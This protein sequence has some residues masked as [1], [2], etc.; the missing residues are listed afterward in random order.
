MDELKSCRTVLSYTLKF[1]LDDTLPEI[2]LFT[3]FSDRHIND[4]TVC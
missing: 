3:G 2:L 1:L 4:A